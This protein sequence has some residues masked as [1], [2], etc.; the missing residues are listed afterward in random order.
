MN[1]EIDTDDP[2]IRLLMSNIIWTYQKQMDADL[3]ARAILEALRELR[4]KVVP[5]PA[6][7]L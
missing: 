6:H 5:L 3:T 7:K 1:I 2:D 4:W